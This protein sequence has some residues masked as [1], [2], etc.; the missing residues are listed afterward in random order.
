[1]LAHKPLSGI[2]LKPAK[3]ASIARVHPLIRSRKV[4]LAQLGF[5]CTAARDQTLPSPARSASL[6]T[7]PAFG[8]VGCRLL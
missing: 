2:G 3:P 7:F 1:M 6:L 4:G 5:V 8:V